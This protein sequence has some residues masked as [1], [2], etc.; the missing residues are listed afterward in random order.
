MNWCTIYYNRLHTIFQNECSTPEHNFRSLQ[1]RNNLF[2]GIFSVFLRIILINF[3]KMWVA[4]NKWKVSMDRETREFETWFFAKLL[5][6]CGDAI[7][8][9]FRLLCCIFPTKQFDYN[10]DDCFRSFNPIKCLN[11]KARIS[12]Q[13]KIYGK[14]DIFPSENRS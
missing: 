7:I 6:F 3:I 1:A 12:M 2:I 10:D 4:H 13:K 5:C 9:L 11:V 14:I 8:T